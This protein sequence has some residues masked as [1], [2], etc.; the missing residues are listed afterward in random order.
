MAV[1][2]QKGGNVSL[3]NIATSVINQ[4]AK[5]RSQNFGQVPNAFMRHAMATSYG[6][7]IV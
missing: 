6:I 4:Q 2:L 5:A 3:D 7:A 1:W